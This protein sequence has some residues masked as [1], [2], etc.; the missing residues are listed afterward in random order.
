MTTPRRRK[1]LQAY[2]EQVR[3]LM[4]LQAWDLEVV[5]KAPDDDDSILSITPQPKRH[6]ASVR[7]GSFFTESALEQR[8]TVVHEVAHLIQGDLL[9]YVD[10]E[11]WVLTLAPDQARTMRERI[12]HELEVHA[13]AYARLL[14]PYM[15]MP[16]RWP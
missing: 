4:R 11:P 10:E 12:H 8:Q 15:P 7:V 3:D 16:P 9:W 2:L 14:A 1:A 13:D 5:D 6:Y